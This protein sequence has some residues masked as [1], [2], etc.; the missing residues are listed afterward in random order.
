MINAAEKEQS[1]F[2]ENEPSIAY[3]DSDQAKKS[4][5]KAAGSFRES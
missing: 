4:Q 5:Q 1:T 3:W 2:E